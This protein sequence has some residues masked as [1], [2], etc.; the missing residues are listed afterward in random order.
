L[1][2]DRQKQAGSA[3]LVHTRIDEKAGQKVARPGLF[4][5]SAV[6]IMSP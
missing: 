4:P 6:V 1:A 5:L 2:L 3:H